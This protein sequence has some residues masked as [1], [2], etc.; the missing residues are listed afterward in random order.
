MK[1]LL[2]ILLFLTGLAQAGFGLKQERYTLTYTQQ[3][4]RIK[5]QI[6]VSAGETAE[7]LYKALR[8][9]PTGQDLHLILDM[10]GGDIAVVNK[11]YDIIRGRCYERGYQRCQITTEVEMFRTCA[12]ACIPLFMVGDH[13]KASYRADFGF[14]QASVAGG[15]I[16]IPFMSEYVLM[17]KGVNPAWLKAHR[18]MFYSLKVTWLNP[19]AMKGSGIV[20][21]ITTYLEN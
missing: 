19:A 21:E 5:G 8:Q 15:F 17:Q 7:S 14:H 10:Y 6:L 11:A 1:G 18:Q 13:R 3:T 9:I 4:L 20:Q 16:M 2:L 12:S